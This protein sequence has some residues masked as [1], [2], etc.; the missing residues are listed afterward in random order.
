MSKVMDG[1]RTHKYSFG[2]VVSVEKIKKNQPI[3]N[4]NLPVAAMIVNSVYS[5]ILLSTNISLIFI[6]FRRILQIFS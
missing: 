4:K 3:R 5:W 1:G 6:S 2:E